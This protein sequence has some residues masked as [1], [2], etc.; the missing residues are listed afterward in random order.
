V[1][2]HK[3][4]SEYLASSAPR[5]GTTGTRCPTD[6]T[7]TGWRRR[8][9]CA[10]E[11]SQGGDSADRP[12]DRA[13]VERTA[14]RSTAARA[15]AP[16]RLH[17]RLRAAHHCSAPTHSALREAPGGVSR[18]QARVIDA[19]L[20]RESVAARPHDSVNASALRRRAFGGFGALSSEAISRACG[21]RSPSRSRGIDASASA[22]SGSCCRACRSDQR[23]RSRVY[24]CVRGCVRVKVR[25][26]VCVH[27]RV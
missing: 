11:R 21:S 18:S 15:A 6:E 17:P 9:R 19:L 14:R 16:R 3:G 13:A 12:I 2:T 24:V 8:C 27:V 4:Y 20:R 22:E 5:V 10:C 26:C 7:R 25:V 23:V 1:S